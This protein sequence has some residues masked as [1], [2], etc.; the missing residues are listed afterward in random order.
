MSEII[1]LYAKYIKATYP[2]NAM[3]TVR[4]VKQ[5]NF[6]GL[7][8]VAV[9]HVENDGTI[10][11]YTCHGEYWELKHGDIFAPYR[12]IARSPRQ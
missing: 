5:Y 2:K 1:N 4:E 3:V 9:H 8:H 7:V 12:Y 6:K 11:G 10:V